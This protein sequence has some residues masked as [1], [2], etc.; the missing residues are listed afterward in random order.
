M[1][2]I[3]VLVFG[4]VFSLCFAKPPR[5]IAISLNRLSKSTTIDE[6]VSFSKINSALILKD[7]SDIIL[8]GQICNK[9]NGLIFDDIC[10]AFNIVLENDSAPSIFIGTNERDLHNFKGLSASLYEPGVANEK[11][12]ATWQRKAGKRPIIVQNINPETHIADLLIKTDVLLKKFLLDKKGLG[13]GSLPSFKNYYSN[14]CQELLENGKRIFVPFNNTFWIHPDSFSIAF[15]E[16]NISVPA[17]SLKLVPEQDN[18]QDHSA[19]LNKLSYSEKFN[20]KLDRIQQKQ[21]LFESTQSFYNILLIANVIYKHNLY[22]KC[23][24]NLTDIAKLRSKSKVIPPD[25]V[26][27]IYTSSYLDYMKMEHQRKRADSPASYYYFY[28]YFQGGI[29]LD[30]L[31][32]NTVQS[33]TDS[34][35]EELS[36]ILSARPDSLTLYWT[37]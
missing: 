8:C 34:R 24:F 25:S 17:N 1:N 19:W 32:P 4:L 31:S 2:K 28:L 5:N 36:R 18:S 26:D 37:Y 21:Q 33:E 27:G 20:S 23:G 12:I 13:I 22:A 29:L 30:Y 15:S 7:N 16:N 6:K 14:Y 3:T 10:Q 11:L 35:Q 9:K